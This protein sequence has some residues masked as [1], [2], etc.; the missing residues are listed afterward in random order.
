VRVAALP[1]FTKLGRLPLLGDVAG[2]SVTVGASV[3]AGRPEPGRLAAT[4]V[5]VVV[6]VVIVVVVVVV[7]TGERATADDAEPVPTAF[8]AATVTEYEVPL[9]SPEIA[10]E[11]VAVEH[12][13][14]DAVDAV[15]PVIAD[16]PSSSGADHVTVICPSPASS[17]T[18][19]GCPGTL[20]VR[21]TVIV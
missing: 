21:V 20:E 3:D 17:D 2:T 1:G 14:P 15:Y 16:P 8:V 10:H 5:V 18:P 7:A 6:V 11:V 4:V 9:S 12:V 19:V 13:E